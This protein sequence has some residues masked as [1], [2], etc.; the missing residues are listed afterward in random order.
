[1][2]EYIQPAP[3]TISWAMG[4]RGELRSAGVRVATDFGDKK[5]ADQIKAAS[6][7]KIPYSIVI[8]ENEKDSGEFVIRNLETGAETK[9]ARTEVSNFFTNL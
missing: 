1:M 5:L 3:G 6:K 8:G 2:A 9:L 7:H 4:N